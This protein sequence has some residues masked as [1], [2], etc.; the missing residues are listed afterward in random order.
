MRISFWWASLHN[1][2]DHTLGQKHLFCDLKGIETDLKALTELIR[3]GCLKLSNTW[4]L[5]VHIGYTSPVGTALLHQFG[6]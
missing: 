6:R 5:E 3:P 1:R 4:S 2:K